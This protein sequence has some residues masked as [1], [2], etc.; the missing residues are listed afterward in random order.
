MAEH[1]HL[2]GPEL[3]HPAWM[4]DQRDDAFDDAALEAAMLESRR[5][6]YEALRELAPAS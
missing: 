6:A 1:L 2:H 3:D 4:A 5:A